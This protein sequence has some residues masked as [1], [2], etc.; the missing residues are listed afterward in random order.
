MIVKN[1]RVWLT[2]DV[3]YDEESPGDIEDALAYVSSME[4]G[5]IGEEAVIMRVERLESEV[6]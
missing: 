1:F 5:Q 4:R 2:I 6:F 3:S